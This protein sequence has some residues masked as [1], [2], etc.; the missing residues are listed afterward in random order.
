MSVERVARAGVRRYA[1][2]VPA[3]YNYRARHNS[4]IQRIRGG[5]HEADFRLLADLDVLEPSVLDVGA[6]AGQTI[7]S[8][9]S[10]FPRSSIT[11]LE[12]S[13]RMLPILN[14]VA[15]KYDDVRILPLGASDRFEITELYVPIVRGLVMA[16][17][18]SVS[19]VSRSAVVDQMA[20]DGFRPGRAGDVVIRTESC[21]FVPL[22]SVADA[23][24]ILKVDV[25]GHEDAVF[26]GASM[27]LQRSRPI[28]I[29]ERPS[30]ALQRH[31]TEL[32]YQ[33]MD[34]G[35]GENRTYV[36]PDSSRGLRADRPR[37]E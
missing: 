20:S 34:G 27:L 6:N 12:P 26:A 7:M 9:K 18:A 32:G 5:I 36:H 21:V 11:S 3:F 24:D 22:D 35:H 25:E 23:C 19:P 33:R 28:V 16:Q 17:Y 37:R 14:R 8:I 15:S 10:I 2:V 30:L 29:V 13:P 1:H 31:I 4:W